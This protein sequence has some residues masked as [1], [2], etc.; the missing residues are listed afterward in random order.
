MTNETPLGKATYYSDRYDPSLLFAIPRSD[1]RGV[2]GLG[3]E[4]P[5]NGCD[6]WT[7]WEI[8]WLNSAGVPQVASAE[9]LVPAYSPFLV[10]SK[11]LK[12]YLGSYAMTRV[13]NLVSLR[14]MIEKDL[15]DCT[16]DVVELRLHAGGDDTDIVEFDGTCIDNTDAE[17]CIYDVDPTLLNSG[18]GRVAESLHSHVLRSLCPVTDQPDLGSVM[19]TYE[20]PKIDPDSLLRYIV[21]FRQHNDFHEACVERMFLDIAERCGP[22]K[23]TVYARYQRR[24]GIDINPFRS[25]FEAPP[26]RLRL[27]RQ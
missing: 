23:L 27:R 17:C 11:S 6:I 21:S 3:N 26:S 19:V 10:E 5:F 24:G 1:S 4:L 12:L 25:N 7:A 8:T 20:G 15:N 2:L 13:D 14:Q 22:E 18:D 16:G 9:I